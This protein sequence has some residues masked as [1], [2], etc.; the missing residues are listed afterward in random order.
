LKKIIIILT[1]KLDFEKINKNSLFQEIENLLKKGKKGNEFKGKSI[2][3]KDIEIS[4]DDN[5]LDQDNIRKKIKE[6]NFMF[7]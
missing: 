7:I 3:I 5:E 1:E 4:Y 2:H 6:S